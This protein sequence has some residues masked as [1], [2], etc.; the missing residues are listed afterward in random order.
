MNREPG[1]A[2][3]SG[4]LQNPVAAVGRDKQIVACAEVEDVTVEIDPRIASQEY[5]PFVLAL[6]V[7]ACVGLGA[8]GDALDAQISTAQQLVEDLPGRRGWLAVEQVA[9]LAQAY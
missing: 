5:D 3:I 4:G 1:A 9:V 8:T 2:R 6:I 7:P